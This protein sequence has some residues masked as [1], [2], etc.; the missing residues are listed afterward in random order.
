MKI[1]LPILHALMFIIVAITFTKL[2]VAGEQKLGAET[3][4][5]NEGIEEGLTAEQAEAFD[6]A[7]EPHLE[8]DQI[9]LPD[10]QILSDFI[11][12][13]EEWFKSLKEPQTSNRKQQ[14]L[15]Q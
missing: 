3:P 10:G 6:A 9:R 14:Q 1:I 7:V 2:A 13:N 5:V 15:N 4:V 12:E 8:A 11:S